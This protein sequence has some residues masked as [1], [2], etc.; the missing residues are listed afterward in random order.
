M[1]E[2]GPIS[3]LVAPLDWGLGHATRCIPIINELIQQGARVI[4]A[5]NPAQYTLLKSEFPQIEFVET[6]VYNIRYK[7]GILLKW[8]LLFRIPS[9]LKQIK[10]ENI[11]LD[12]TL[13]HHPID[14]VIS[15]S[16]YGL[17]HKACPCVFVTHQLQIQSGIGTSFAALKNKDLRS[18]VSRKSFFVGRWSLAIGRWID[19]RILKWNYAF[20][21]KFSS[22]WIPDLDGELSIAGLLSHP[23]KPPSVTVRYIGPLS[24]FYKLEK[25]IQKNAL[26]ILLSGP[27]PQRT[28]FENILFSQLASSTI[29]TVVVRGLPGSDSGIPYIREG[30]RIWNHLPSDAL[31]TLLNNSEYIVAR[32]GY[33]T[34]MDLLAVKKNAILVPTP[35][36]TEQ[37]YLGYYLHEKKWMYSV[38]QKNFNL[39]A[40]MN[41]FENAALVLPEIPCTNLHNVIEEFLRE[42]SQRK[43]IR[44]K[45]IESFAS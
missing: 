45:G 41:A 5:A 6:P 17:F 28:D 24:R 19:Q 2:N 13:R 26:F 25:N 39:Q 9:M 21:E 4:V 12:E 18:R 14:A 27:E 42:L 11:W 32:S 38:A 3:V 30:V 34:V 1:M 31:N 23:A 10:R 37:E 33:S 16:R 8:N 35:G 44:G 22:C 7:G 15:D 40:A 43:E 36:Q 20:I 29:N